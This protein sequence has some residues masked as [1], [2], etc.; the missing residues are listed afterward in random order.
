MLSEGAVKMMA[1]ELAHYPE[2]HVLGALRKCCKELKGKLT[3]ADILSRLDDGRPGAEE[4]WSIVYRVLNDERATVVWTE[5][6]REAY[7][8]VAPL[9][10]DAIAARMAFK[11]RYTELVRQA[12]DRHEPAKWSAS[13]GYDQQ[14]RQDAISEAVRSGRLTYA[15]GQRICPALPPVGREAVKLLADMGLEKMAL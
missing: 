3:L 9:A 12:R 1:E 2:P 13:L 10:E 11:E 4:A 15:E 6:M 7:G 5:E 8:V 14:Q